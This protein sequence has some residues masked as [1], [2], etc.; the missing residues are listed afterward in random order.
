MQRAPYEAVVGKTRLAD[1]KR[2][3]RL[4]AAHA[5]ELAAKAAGDART[6]ADDS[7]VRVVF[8]AGCYVILYDPISMCFKKQGHV[9]T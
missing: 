6:A 2:Q 4:Q 7:Q 3:L 9:C 1:L 8:G 5:R